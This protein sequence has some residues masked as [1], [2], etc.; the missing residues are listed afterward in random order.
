MVI[1]AIVGCS[2]RS[3]TDKVTSIVGCSNR[4]GR[5]KVTFHRLPVVVKHQGPQMLEITSERRKAWLAAISREDLKGKR[6]DKVF[7]C[8]HHFVNSKFVDFLFIY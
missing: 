8:S 5:D 7:I 6:L 2:N 4:S 1:C 3:G